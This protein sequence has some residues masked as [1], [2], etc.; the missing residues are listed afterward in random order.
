MK[1]FKKFGIT[2]DKWGYIRFLYADFYFDFV[3]IKRNE[4]I[5]IQVSDILFYHLQY[6]INQVKSKN[7]CVDFIAKEKGSNL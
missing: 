4:K 1:Y 2:S 3:A 6:N 7:E 5:Y